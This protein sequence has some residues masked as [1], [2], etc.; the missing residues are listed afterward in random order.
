MITNGRE[1]KSETLTGFESQ[2]A[3]A[4]A[5]VIGKTLR[6]KSTGGV[7]C[8]GPIT[9]CEPGALRRAKRKIT[10]MWNVRIELDAN[11]VKFERMFTVASLPR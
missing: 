3:S 10:Q 6:I 11:G 2:I 7:T 8:E 1:R 5:D 9:A 4:C